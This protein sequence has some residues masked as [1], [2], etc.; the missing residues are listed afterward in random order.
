[1]RNPLVAILVALM[2]ISPARATQDQWPALFDVTGV[3]SDDVL[4]IRAAPDASSEIFG[5]LR[6]NATGIEVIRPNDRETWGLVNIDGRVGWVS[7][8]FM[9]R[10]PGQWL[11]S[12]PA[13]QSCAGTEPFWSLQFD[14]ERLRFNTAELSA[15]GGRLDRWPSENRRDAHGFSLRVLPDAGP[16]QD[17]LAIV[18][19]QRC[20]DGMSDREYGLRVDM[21]LGSLMEQRL[22]SG[23]CTLQAP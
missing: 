5:A 12:E 14:G 20:V 18:T 16:P 1:M 11:G 15:T 9:A 3:A 21:L 17:G 4:N 2:L 19:L 23:C 10:R 6:H 7:L 13:V 8:S 22:W